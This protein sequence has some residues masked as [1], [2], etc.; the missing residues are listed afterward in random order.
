M[1]EGVVCDAGEGGRGGAEVDGVPETFGLGGEKGVVGVV[2]AD[3]ERSDAVEGVDLDPMSAA[4]GGAVDAAESVG[5]ATP[6]TEYAYEPGVLCGVIRVDD[7]VL[8]PV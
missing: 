5:C 2:G 7:D 8:G 3:R 4:V 6:T 1:A